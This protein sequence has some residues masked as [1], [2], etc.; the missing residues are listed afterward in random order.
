MSAEIL[1]E[2]LRRFLLLLV[3]FTCTGTIVELLLMEH[4][5]ESNQL[6]PFALCGLG[7]VAALGAL[8]YPQR[9][10]IL[11]LRLIM[12]L[13]IGG[14][15]LGIYF[16]LQGNFGFELE[17]RP[18]ATWTDVIVEAFMGANP[19]FAPATLA[20]AGFLGLAASYYHPTLSK[21]A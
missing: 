14:S 11:A 16:H 5:D 15:L 13:L 7:F 18:N 2:R 1:L 17:M 4:F 3:A 9:R 10:T 6:I 12:L 8:F 19:I 20:L 21:A